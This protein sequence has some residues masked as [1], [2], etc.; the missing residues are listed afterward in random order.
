[1]PPLDA[2]SKDI[3]DFSLTFGLSDRLECVYCGGLA[4]FNH[5]FS[6]ASRLE[7]NFVNDFGVCESN[8]ELLRVHA[9]CYP[10]LFSVGVEDIGWVESLVE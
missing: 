7:S 6:C 8:S 3:Q 2:S 9:C 5:D 1:M 4:A 10:E